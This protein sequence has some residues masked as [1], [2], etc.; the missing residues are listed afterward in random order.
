MATLLCEGCH[1]GQ[2]KHPG[3]KDAMAE[4]FRDSYVC[5]RCPLT[6]YSA[7]NNKL[8]KSFFQKPSKL[9]GEL[10][11]EIPEKRKISVRTLWRHDGRKEN[12]R[13]HSKLWFSGQVWCV[14]E[15]PDPN[16]TPLCKLPFLKCKMLTSCMVHFV[17]SLSSVETCWEWGNLQIWCQDRQI[18]VITATLELLSIPRWNS[19]SRATY[20]CHSHTINFATYVSVLWTHISPWCMI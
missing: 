8:S 18:Y 19:H 11:V 6:A 13:A 5:G 3:A 14:E 15:E 17:V 16:K 12:K 4:G 2:A 10:A 7:C 20:S 1:D 9:V